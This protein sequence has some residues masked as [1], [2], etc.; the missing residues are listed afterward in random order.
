MHVSS[1]T[2]DRA[3]QH[4]NEGN[5][6]AFGTS[7]RSRTDENVDECLQN[8]C[9]EKN[10]VQQQM[11][12]GRSLVRKDMP[13]K[14]DRKQISEKI[15]NLYRVKSMERNQEPPPSQGSKM[16]F[17]TTGKDSRDTG[18]VPADS[19]FG[20]YLRKRS[21]KVAAMTKLFDNGS[22]PRPSVIVALTPRRQKPIF[23]A[24]SPFVEKERTPNSGVR[25]PP[26]PPPMPHSI[27]KRKSTISPKSI[28]EPWTGNSKTS[29][30]AKTKIDQSRQHA[31]LH[32][33]PSQ[34]KGRSINEKVQLFESVQD[35]KGTGPLTKRSIFARKLSRSLKSL[36]EHPSR[37]SEDEEQ[38][39]HGLDRKKVQNIVDEV[40]DAHKSVKIGKRMGTLV[41]RWNAIPPPQEANGCDGALSEKGVGSPSASE[42]REMVVKEA[43]CGLKEPKPVRVAEVKR[44]MLICKERFGD[45]M[46]KERSTR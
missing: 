43:E 45:M 4:R 16:S 40:Q 3:R 29:S 7:N 9:A 8:S 20:K 32:K 2:F 12:R 23:S 11:D 35:G 1:R 41:G 30:I 46:D 44:M 31:L 6:R 26:N 24:S 14:Y 36:F 21:S 17:T 27:A 5:S 39:R 15:E 18:H 42:V 25:A 38:A 19:D 10:S 37:R 28:Q 33:K 22:P 13:T 34:P